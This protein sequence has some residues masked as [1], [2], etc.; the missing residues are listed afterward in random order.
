MLQNS[1]ECVAPDV[2]MRYIIAGNEKNTTDS[3]FDVLKI[4]WIG[5]IIVIVILIL[6]WAYKKLKS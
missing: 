5:G 1:A 3:L 2:A 6:L 4:I